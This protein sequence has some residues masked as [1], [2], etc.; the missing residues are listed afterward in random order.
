MLQTYNPFSNKNTKQNKIRYI[1]NISHKKQTN[2]SKTVNETKTK[3][4]SDKLIIIIIIG[5]TR[6]SREQ[7]ISITKKPNMFKFQDRENL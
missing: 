1:S 5:D 3:I 4:N 2:K 7:M 6:I